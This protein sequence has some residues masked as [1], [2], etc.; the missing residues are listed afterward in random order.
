MKNRLF[1]LESLSPSVL[2]FALTEH[3]KTVHYHAHEKS[4]NE[5]AVNLFNCRCCLIFIGIN[6]YKICFTALP[7]QI[8]D[9]TIKGII[10]FF[11][12]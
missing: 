10:F 2:L 9:M 1:L 4:V 12:F 8:N 11:F 7:K 6:P 5:A 3:N